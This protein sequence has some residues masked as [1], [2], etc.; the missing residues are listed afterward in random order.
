M[1]AAIARKYFASGQHMNTR[2]S[3]HAEDGK[4]ETQLQENRL[5]I[6]MLSVL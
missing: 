3:R 6:Q 4:C 1:D 2:H 5:Y